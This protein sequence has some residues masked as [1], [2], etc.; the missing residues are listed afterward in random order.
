MPLF[1]SSSSTTGAAP[2]GG[3]TG[4]V[5]KKSSG[6][7]YDYAWATDSTAAGSDTNMKSVVA[8]YGAFADGTSHLLSAVYGSLAAAQAVFPSATALTQETDY[9]AIQ[10][11]IA[12]GNN[13]HFGYGTSYKLGTFTTTTYIAGIPSSNLVY[14]FENVTF[15]AA[16]GSSHVTFMQ[17]EN[18]TNWRL[19]GKWTCVDSDAVEG[20]GGGGTYGIY[21]TAA[22]GARGFYCVQLAGTWSDVKVDDLNCVGC[23]Y[24]IQSIPGSGRGIGG[25][26]FKINATNTYYP[27]DLADNGDDCYASVR[28]TKCLRP[29]FL[30]GVRNVIL[31]VWVNEPSYSHVSIIKRS[32][33]D[34]TGIKIRMFV[35]KTDSSVYARDWV[36]IE[37]QCDDA[38]ASV[39]SDID[40]DITYTG[41]VNTNTPLEAYYGLVFL[42]SLSAAGTTYGAYPNSDNRHTFRDIRVKGNRGT[43][44]TAAGGSNT[45]FSYVIGADF[46]TSTTSLTSAVTVFGPGAKNPGLVSAGG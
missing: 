30:Y 3:T 6:T 38:A 2:T 15:T 40:I 43:G 13:L 28:A 46:V 14:L 29:F 11:A 17:F 8:D 44:G 9:V 41:T 23:Y 34:T 10:K 45:D 42:R 21:P 26:E 27:I 18:K 12:S 1:N 36:S 22:G 33:R 31:D 37:H 39:I 35:R 4:Q 24:G 32:L 25:G 5:L 7:N 16:C 20:A 19:K